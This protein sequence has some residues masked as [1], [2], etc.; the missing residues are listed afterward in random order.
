MV[1]VDGGLPVGVALVVEV[2][3]AD[4]TEVTGM[5]LV[6]VDTVVVLATG[7]TATGGMLTVLADT[8]VTAERG[9]T[10]VADLLETSGHAKS[11][12]A[13]R[14]VEKRE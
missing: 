11:F 13:G 14:K 4:L 3:H 9:T 1:E 7:V 2:A 5:V 12:W 10:L 8:T 6:E